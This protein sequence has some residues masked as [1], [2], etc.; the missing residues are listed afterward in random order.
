MPAE[1]IASLAMARIEVEKFLLKVWIG[2]LGGSRTLV[3]IKQLDTLVSFE[4]L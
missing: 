4:M 3:T 1:T 2:C